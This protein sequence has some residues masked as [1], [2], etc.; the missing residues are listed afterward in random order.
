MDWKTVGII[1]NVSKP[2]ALD[3][4]RAVKGEFERLGSVVMLEAATARC[5]QQT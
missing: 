1:A 5:M 3:L 4:L 2:G